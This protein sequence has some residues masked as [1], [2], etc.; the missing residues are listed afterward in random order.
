M[1]LL[2]PPP[3]SQQ[4]SSVR[5]PFSHSGR[6]SSPSSFIPS[7]LCL[8]QLLSLDTVT[9]D[10]I[11]THSKLSGAGSL[12][13]SQA[14]GAALRI[15]STAAAC[16]ER[17]SVWEDKW[18][19]DQMKPLEDFDLSWLFDLRLLT[20]ECI[21]YEVNVLQVKVKSQG[22]FCL[23]VALNQQTMAF[24]HKKKHSKMS[25]LLYHEWIYSKNI[26][27]FCFFL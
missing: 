23:R 4:C 3:A 20:R 18:G 16:L 25:L 27:T 9:G 22:A 21:Q 26:F 2:P 11:L 10:K 15:R 24:H 17:C 12:G 14:L 13:E 6:P 1:R 8:S 7:S 5:L 19:S